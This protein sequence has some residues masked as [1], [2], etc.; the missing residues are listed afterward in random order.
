MKLICEKLAQCPDVH[1][2]LNIFSL[3][4]GIYVVI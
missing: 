3:K 4:V 1:R 2:N